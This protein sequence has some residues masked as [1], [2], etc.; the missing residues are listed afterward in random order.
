MKW[1]KKKNPAS[2]D[3]A[4]STSVRTTAKKQGIHT[5]SNKDLQTA[6]ERMRLEQDFKRLRVNERPAV[7]RWI[8]STL[9]EAGKR[10]VQTRAVKKIGGAVL[11][12]S[13]G[14]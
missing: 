2:S 10:E 5:L 8:A 3:A 1:G 13:V 11:K 7:T 4:A 14:A 9:L 6:I 12:K